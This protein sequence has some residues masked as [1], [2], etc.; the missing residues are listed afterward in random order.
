VLRAGLTGGVASGKS[1]FGE[2]LAARG[3][4]VLD[5][6]AVVAALYAPGGAGAQAVRA[7]FGPEA[8]GADGGVDRAR[9]SARVLADS[10]ARSRLEAA[11]H[12]L[13]RS[14]VTRWLSGLER[15]DEAPAA[16]VVEAALLV[17]TGSYRDYHRL[18][19]VTAPLELR[20][21]RAL[22]AGW[23]ADRFERTLAAQSSDDDRAA[24]ADYLVSNCAD[25]A[26]LAV[27]AARL[28]PLL[29]E[30]ARALDRRLP[31]PPRR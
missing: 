13:V 29:L 1:A 10:G 3:A 2:L 26:E 11:V 24:A 25:V 15:S 31:L 16:A 9:L 6:D 7:V 12:P 17:E 22:A 18:I 30:D 27:A 14:E 19:V 28:W 4:A 23:S 21:A 8:L 20:R 5:A